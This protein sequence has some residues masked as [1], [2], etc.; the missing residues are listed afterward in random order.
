MQVLRAL[1]L[2]MLLC[3]SFVH[4]APFPGGGEALV[5]EA[6]EWV[7][8]Q[9]GFPQQAIEITAP[10]RRVSIESCDQTLHFRFPFKGNQRTIEAVCSQPSWK[11]F[12]RVKI[13]DAQLVLAA[14]RDLPSGHSLSKGDLKLVPKTSDVTGAI[15]D[16]NSALG[17]TLNQSITQNTFITES[18]LTSEIKAFITQRAYEAGEEIKRADVS[19]V[20]Q[21]Q[22]KDNTLTQWPRG[23]VTAS[24]YIEPKHILS[25][26]DVEQSEYVIVSATNIVRGQ[27]ITSELVERQVRA[28]NTIGAQT[29]ST[30]EQ[31]IG[32]EAT[33]TIRAGTALSVSDLTAADLVRKGEKVTLIVSRGALTISVETI[34]LH[35]A[36]MGEQVEL[37][38]TESGRVVRGIVT[39]RHQAK[40]I[41]R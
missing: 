8:S 24:K 35:D 30:I 33:R 23:L 37:S 12:M 2:L 7:S 19:M 3:S 27:V 18:I 22:R 26:D 21:D 15:S 6:K 20:V 13:I 4:S 25:K 38:N 11:R 10:D 31:A 5:S 28:S 41:S 32:L 29:L 17:L 14:S 9:T 16:F 40:G 1:C 36:K 39:G 34:A